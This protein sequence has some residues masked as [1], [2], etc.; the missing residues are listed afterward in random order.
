GRELRELQQAILADD[1]ALRLPAP[2]VAVTAEAAG[3]AHGLVPELLPPD[4][5]DFTGREAALAR[6]D[7]LFGGDATAST[8]VITAIAGAAG[9]GKTALAVHAAHRLR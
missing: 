9:V 5:A 6:L 3:P 4:V 7:G 2:P 1:P 8:V